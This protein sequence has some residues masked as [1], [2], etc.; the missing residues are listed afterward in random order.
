MCGLFV[1]PIS[2]NERVWQNTT[3]GMTLFSHL[4]VFGNIAHVHV[5]DEQRSK[6]DDKSEKYIFIDYD[7][8]SKGYK[9]YNTNTG[10]T[11]IV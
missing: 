10:K 1:Q 3:K 6:L 7:T 5:P 8:N 9:L 4:R 2:N 11:V